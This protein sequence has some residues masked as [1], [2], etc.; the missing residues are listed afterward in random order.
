MTDVGHWDFAP[1]AL[2]AAFLLHLLRVRV[3][4]AGLGEIAREMLFGSSSAVSE[5]DVITVVELVGAGHCV[6]GGLAVSL[7]W[8]LSLSNDGRRCG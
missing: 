6:G 7:S 1:I 4:V 5:S 2:A 3:N 8:S